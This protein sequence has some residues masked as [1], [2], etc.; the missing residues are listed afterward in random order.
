LAHERRRE[1]KE[2]T[3]ETVDSK[4]T[5]EVRAWA[6]ESAELRRRLKVRAAAFALGM[7]LLT[8]VWVVGEYLSAGGWPQHLSG[9]DYPGDWSP[10]I[11]WVALAWGFYVAMTALVLHYRRPPVGEREIERE[12]A[13]LAAHSRG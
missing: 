11:I 12:L 7:L 4:R 5:D 10:W 1:R 8:P 13:R 3:M 2:I 9:N 6:R